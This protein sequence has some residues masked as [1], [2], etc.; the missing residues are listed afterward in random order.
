MYSRL[1][2][3]LRIRVNGADHDV[4]AEPDTPLLYVLRN[5][6]GSTVPSS[7]AGSGSVAPAPCTRWGTTTFVRD[8]VSASRGKDVTDAR[9]PRGTP[10]E[11]HPLQQA[12]IDEQAAQCGYCMNGL[13][14][15]GASA[16][17]A[18][19]ASPVARRDPVRDERE[20]A[21]GAGRTCASCGRSN[22]P[23]PAARRDRQDG[24]ADVSTSS[25]SR[26][27][28][29]EFLADA[30]LLIVGFT[31]FP[32]GVRADS[33]GGAKGRSTAPSA[34]ALD[35]WLVIGRDDRVTVYAGKVELGTGVSTALR[36]IVAEELDVAPGRIVWVQGTASSRS[37]RAAPLE[38][39]A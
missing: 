26:R 20:P 10:G 2:T 33:L 16:L 34:D 37:I 39:A 15:T 19:D 38:A 24:R 6:L 17:L 35:S 25:A 12:F 27:S 22:A 32:R 14:M 8:A 30:G 21:A 5:E 36:Q 13:I 18:A 9:G 11:P 23:L 1:S 3:A 7:A 31:L 29:R 28:R 4:A